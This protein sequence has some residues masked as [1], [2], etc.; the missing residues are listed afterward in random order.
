MASEEGN[1]EVVK[2]LLEK[3]EININSEDVFLFNLK[4]ISII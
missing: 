3:E 2:S 4:F 1:I